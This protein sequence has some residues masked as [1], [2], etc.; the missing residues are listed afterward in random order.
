[1]DDI[2]KEGAIQSVNFVNVMFRVT[3]DQLVE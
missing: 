1:M 2:I 3:V